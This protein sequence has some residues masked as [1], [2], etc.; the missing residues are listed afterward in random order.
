MVGRSWGDA[1]I[2][3]VGWE[4]V[5]HATPPV[6]CVLRV[7][8]AES[9]QRIIVRRALDGSDLESPEAVIS[10]LEATVRGWNRA[11][12]AFVWGGKRRLRRERARARRLGGSGA[13][14]RV[15]GLKS[16][17]HSK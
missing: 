17:A 16:G 4:L 14:V 13:T 12:T 6:R 2:H 15:D 10:A 3:S 8:K 5:K 9:I 7:K 1:G 11:P